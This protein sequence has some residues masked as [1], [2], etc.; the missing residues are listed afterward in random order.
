MLQAMKQ[1]LDHLLKVNKCDL[2]FSNLPF[3]CKNFNHPK[4][5]INSTNFSTGA[6]SSGLIFDRSKSQR[7][8]ERD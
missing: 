6:I 1:P 7:D 5:S 4:L 3:A 2:R 8:H